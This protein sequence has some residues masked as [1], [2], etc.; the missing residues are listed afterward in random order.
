M[1]LRESAQSWANELAQR[2]ECEGDEC[3]SAENMKIPG[4][5]AKA[6]NVYM[7]CNQ[8]PQ[9]INAIDGWKNSPGHNAHML[10][11]FTNVGF[12]VGDAS[13]CREGCKMVRVVALYG[14]PSDKP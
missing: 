5:M 13:G 6:E 12:G 9:A 14:L 4:Y 7:E 10:G 2:C 8:S 11:S 3:H 1:T